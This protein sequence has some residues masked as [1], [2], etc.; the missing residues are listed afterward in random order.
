MN[1]DPFAIDA[2]PGV[3]WTRAW[4]DAVDAALCAC[5]DE[6][7]GSGVAVVAL[8]SYARRE[9]CPRSDIDLLLL[10]DGR[11]SAE[12]ED[13]VR[14]LCYPLWD[15][16]LEVGYA[17]HTP[18]QAAGAMGDGLDTTTALTVRRL[19]AGDR[20]LADALADR[21]G[22][23]L[24]R[25]G[26]A[27]LLD[28]ER[29][30]DTRRARDGA[31][32]GMLEPDLKTDPGGLRDL[33][34]FS[35]AAACVLGDVGL[36]PLVGARY[37]S[38]AERAQLARAG[39]T[40]LEA[41]C[42][43]HLT[44]PRPGT[45]VLRLD[46]QDEVAVRLGTDG[47][48]LLRR[49][50]IAMR[51]VA[52]VRGRAFRTIAGDAAK[53]RRRRKPPPEQLADGVVLVDGLVELEGGGVVD[54]ALALRA[55]AAAATRGTHLGRATHDALAR[56][57]AGGAALPW[58]P[59]ML[60][61]FVAALAAGERALGALRDADQTGLLGALLPEWERVRGR[62]QRNPY[63]RYDLDT[64]LLVTLG[65][66][67]QVA[68]GALSA[69]HATVWRAVPDPAVV[70]LGAFLHDVGKAWPGDH[71]E[72][73]A[74]VAERWLAHMGVAPQRRERV[75]RLVR[76]HLLLPD[77]A[78]RRDIDDEAEVVRVTEQAGS[79][80]T[81]DGLYLLSLADG[82]AT[83]PSAHSPWKEALLAT[84]HARARRVLLEDTTG[85]RLADPG[86]VAARARDDAAD[87]PL[88]ASVEGLLGVLPRR[89]LL[90]ASAEQVLAHAQ[91]VDAWTRTGKPQAAVRPAN[92]A[93]TSVLSVAAPDR[94]GLVADCAGLLAASGLDVVEARAFTA[95][96]T[97][98]SD[99]ALDWFVV[100]HDERELPADIVARVSRAAAGVLDVP[101]ALAK[102]ARRRGARIRALPE[103]IA[104]DVRI[105][106]DGAAG[107]VEVHA[108]DAPGLLSRLARVLSARDVDLTGARVATLGP[109]VRDVFFV[110]W[111]ADVDLTGLEDALRREAGAGAEADD[112]NAGPLL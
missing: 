69:D 41:R 1:L 18:A 60:D 75:A 100:D 13:L 31:H 50:G 8:G 95:P 6:H 105:E 99:L 40:L 106:H 85:A 109:A 22:R 39:E 89:Y 15:A 110:R 2:P 87:T 10:H 12:L 33:H 29:T 24:R 56:A 70:W 28:V 44:A 82:R 30:A 53:G 83:G 81:L 97:E 38:A 48:E 94:L 52:H 26:G 64:H 59:G 86:R 16:G 90:A 112:A 11:G 55:I 7:D 46:L 65:W 76:H 23:W 91:L 68:D 102:R 84:L 88:A 45:N 4:T 47:D 43:L 79:V 54:P 101:A 92:A 14:A 111:P 63:H 9:L 49:V 107:R 103:H 42:A 3:A 34:A 93:D 80:E 19:V 77:A 58:Q 21:V 78:T 74:E 57:L 36:D 32:P 66:L 25:H 27:L 104:V 20:G 71:S 96:T 72:V 61:D 73:G 51:T 62:R 5:L 17:V 67:R 37:L 108:P 35:W 98:G